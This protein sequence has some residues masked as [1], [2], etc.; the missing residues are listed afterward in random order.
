MPTA[1]TGSQ[2][3][4]AVVCMARLVVASVHLLTVMVTSSD[5]DVTASEGVVTFMLV[6]RWVPYG[7]VVR[8]RQVHVAL[9]V[10]AVVGVAVQARPSGAL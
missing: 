6:I 8:T 9:P 3:M 1:P 10:A 4:T 5:V 2:E 7:A